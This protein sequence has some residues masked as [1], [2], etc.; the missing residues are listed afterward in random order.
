MGDATWWRRGVIY[1]LYPRSFM[2]SDGEPAG[3]TL[4][5]RG[6]EGMVVGHGG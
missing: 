4:E 5:L 2:D 3:S 6:G 1:Q